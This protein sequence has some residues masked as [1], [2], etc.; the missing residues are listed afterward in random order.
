MPEGDTI[1]RT[2]VR[3]RR[4]WT[5]DPCEAVTAADS[6]WDPSKL[7]GCRVS[8]IE[9]AWQ[10]SVDPSGRRTCDS[11]APGNDGS[12]AYLSARPGM[13]ETG[14]PC[15]IS[16]GC[17]IIRLCLFLP[18]DTRTVNDSTTASS[19]ASLP[20]RS[21]FA[22]SSIRCRNRIDSLSSLQHATDRRSG[23][24]SND[25]L[26]HRK[27]LQIGSSLSSAAESISADSATFRRR[28]P[29]FAAG[30]LSN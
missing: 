12:V 10:A 20:T 23:D 2:A 16:L 27:R 18:E 3:L 6:T 1:F 25:R 24:E 21:R 30:P 7:T 14:P 5:G 11:L 9:A 8:A 29:R 22:G 4:F 28:N 15:R 17:R 13:A 19:S 26:R